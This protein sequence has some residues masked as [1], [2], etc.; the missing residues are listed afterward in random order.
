[1]GIPTRG[2]KA[3]EAPRCGGAPLSARR[4]ETNRSS[5]NDLC[6]IRAGGVWPISLG[7]KDPLVEDSRRR[8]TKVYRPMETATGQRL[9]RKPSARHRAGCGFTLFL[10]GCVSYFML[11]LGM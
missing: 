1:M 3:R 2:P 8:T 7:R 9:R 4:N 5:F 6:E 10:G 11:R